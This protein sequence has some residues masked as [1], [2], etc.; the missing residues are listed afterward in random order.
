MLSHML[1]IF[2]SNP[3]RAEVIADARDLIENTYIAVDRSVDKQNFC[4]EIR[5]KGCSH[6]I[7][8]MTTCD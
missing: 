5:A 8:G 1:Q 7:R 4:N 6:F 3:N 2:L